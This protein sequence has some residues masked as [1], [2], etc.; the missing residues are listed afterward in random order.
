[1]MLKKYQ[2][3]LVYVL[4]KNSISDGG[5]GV[6]KIVTYF[7]NLCF[8]ATLLREQVDLKL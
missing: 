7:F 8:R 5:V 3:L 2:P 1:M 6:T 4:I